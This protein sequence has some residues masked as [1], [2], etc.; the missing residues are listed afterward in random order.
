MGILVRA[1]LVLLV[2]AIQIL[3]VPRVLEVGA[4]FVEV[5]VLILSR[6][7]WI[8]ALHVVIVLVRWNILSR[9]FFA[10]RAACV[11]ILGD[12]QL[13]SICGIHSLLHF[14]WLY[15]VLL[16]VTS[17]D[18]FLF[19]LFYT[20]RSYWTMA[21]S[22][23]IDVCHIGL[24]RFIFNLET[25]LLFQ[26]QLAWSVDWLLPSFG[27]LL[28]QVASGCRGSERK[29]RTIIIQNS[30][31]RPSLDTASLSFI[32]TVCNN[33]G[34]FFD[35]SWFFLLNFFFW[36]VWVFKWIISILKFFLGVFVIQLG[37]DRSFL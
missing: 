22:T 27:L 7:S 24:Q 19:G 18:Q 8:A 30:P 23:D 29:L 4:D 15:V 17:L 33:L 25:G 34:V 36:Q 26:R 20:Q 1:V 16:F 32:L 28:V 5:Q 2:T 11:V 10:G 3:N 12:S 13:R 21:L 14:R 35:E 9:F 37:F 6:G 31:L